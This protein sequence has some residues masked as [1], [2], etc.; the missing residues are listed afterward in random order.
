VIVEVGLLL[1]A[2]LA[3]IQV[4][5]SD[6]GWAQST[7]TWFAEYTRVDHTLNSGEVEQRSVTLWIAERAGWLRFAGAAG[8][9]VIIALLPSYGTD[10]L[11]T[12]TVLT[13]LYFGGI[14]L[15][16]GSAASEGAETTPDRMRDQV[17]GD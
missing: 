4:L 3:L 13:L 6:A 8:L 16:A 11:V 2:Y 12:L 10:A 5:V 15:I 17:T 14:E 1:L 9:I 7:R